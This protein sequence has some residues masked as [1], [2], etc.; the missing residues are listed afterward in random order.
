MSMD[1]G[2]EVTPGRRAALEIFGAV[3]RGQRVDR[4]FADAARD[5]D[6]RERAW[7]RELV[8]GAQRLRG[9]L[10]YLL[11]RRVRRGLDSVDSEVLDVLRLGMYQ[12][13]YM[14]GVPEYAA[15]SQTVDLA[16]SVGG[17][18]TAG[19]VNAIMRATVRERPGEEH[20][21]DFD[22]DPAGSLSTWGSHP[23]WLVERWLGRWS[24]ADVQR[25]VEANNEVP[26]IYLRCLRDTPEEASKA[27]ADAGIG[28]EPAGS[29]TG[30]A[31]SGTGCVVLLQGSSPLEAMGV[32]PSVVQDPAAAL[33]VPYADPKP[34]DRVADL[35]AAPGGKAMALAARG[36]VVL[37][38][39]RSLE[40]LRLVR[41]NVARLSARPWTGSNF[42]V[43]LVQADALA[44]IA[45]GADMVLLDVP[46]TGTGT[47]RR[48]PDARWKLTP[49]RL[50]ELVRLQERILE[51]CASVV[52]SGGRLV[53]STC[54]LEPEENEDRI[55]AF[56][57]RH[58]EFE[59]EPSA[60]VEDQ[61]VNEWG[62]L[63]V[64]P[65]KYGFD[66]A[67]AARLRKR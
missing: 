50:D 13:L 64:L 2:A 6:A 47:L 25:L 66:G 14:D 11:D 49:E 54:S 61:Y 9:R 24:A 48:N 62:H 38:A 33:V 17:K 15:V 36:N 29:G 52:P 16:R 19:F 32:V 4:A 31:G 21:P 41:D 3:E 18:G 45:E 20:F 28:A 58:P 39:D 22:S 26:P 30:S 63:Y 35:C 8:Y 37:A 34:G 42:S 51:A 59:L 60:G 27:L 1:S 10:D 65:Q 67:F 46:C 7:C 53:Y 23:R 55:S 40:R 43:S 5:L 44:P 56:L 12:V 57:E